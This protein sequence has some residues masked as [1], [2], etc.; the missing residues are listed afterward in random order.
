MNVNGKYLKDESGKVISPVTSA[1][2]VFD[3]NSIPLEK[4]VYFQSFLWTNQSVNANTRTLINFTSHDNYSE[5][6]MELSDG[7]FSINVPGTYIVNIQVHCTSTNLT[8]SYR[9]L[10]ECE[11][12]TA[13]GGHSNKYRSMDNENRVITGDCCINA[14]WIMNLNSGSNLRFYLYPINSSV[15]IKGI[16]DSTST[17]NVFT[18]VFIKR[19]SS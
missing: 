4:G 3:S 15:V 11:T 18:Q 5:D 14:T 1:K 7:E 19:L 8:I 12:D 2:T 10:I 13:I 9:A 17:D 6:L 16:S